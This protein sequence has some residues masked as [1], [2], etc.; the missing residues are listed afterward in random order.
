VDTSSTTST[1]NVKAKAEETPIVLDT[2][3]SVSVTP[4]ASD[5]I[6]TIQPAHIKA[7][8]SLNGKI[9]VHGVGIVEWTIQDMDGK[10]SKVRTKA[11]YCPTGEVR[12]F[13]PQVYF[14]ENQ[15]GTLICDHNKVILNLADGVTLSFPWQP[16]SKLPMMLTPEMCEQP[17]SS[18]FVGLTPQDLA[19]P[20]AAALNQSFPSVLDPRN[21]NL[22]G[23][24]KE[25]LLWL[26]RLGHASL[27]RVQTLLS[28]PRTEHGRQVLFPVNQ[29]VTTCELP[30]CAA[31]QYAKQK[32]HKP[33]LQSHTTVPENEGGLS[34]NIL[35]PGQR[36]TCDLYQSPILGRLQHTQGKEKDD[37]KHVGGAIFMDV[38]TNYIF[39]NH[40]P[41]LTAGMT[42]GSKHLLKSFA[43][44]YGV[45]IKEYQG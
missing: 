24:Q 6:D 32:Q 41:N 17:M 28:Q 38:A 8:N 14:M 37:V 42:V 39:I 40:Q 13:S 22:T 21:L 23:S 31:C 1:Y 12:L 5:F 35:E 44:E 27:K 43:A 3:A 11:L 45:K 2:G 10:V 34:D 20:I 26:Q 30:K 36:V 9:K 19:C 7:L 33:P 4:H 29:R 15:K 16:N 25:L 18:H